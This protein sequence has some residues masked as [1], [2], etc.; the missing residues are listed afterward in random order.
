M[1]TELCRK[2]SIFLV[3]EVGDSAGITSWHIGLGPTIFW[4]GG[5]G[6]GTETFFRARVLYDMLIISLIG[7]YRSISVNFRSPNRPWAETPSPP[8]LGIFVYHIF[9]TLLCTKLLSGDLQ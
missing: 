6:G 3:E 8:P 9:L 4:V 7:L 5:G 2:A 1:F